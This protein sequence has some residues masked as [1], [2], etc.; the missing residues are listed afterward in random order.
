MK[1]IRAL[2]WT[3]CIMM[4][5]LCAGGCGG[6]EEDLPPAE[7]LSQ[8][9]ALSDYSAYVTLGAYTGFEIP[10]EDAEVSQEEMEERIA[11]TV[12]AY[13]YLYAAPEAVTDRAVAEGDMINI[14]FSTTVDGEN[15]EALFGQDVSYQIGSGQI[16][17]ALDAQ[18]VGKQPGGAY[19]LICTFPEDTAF[20]GLEGKTA[21]FHVTVNYIYGAIQEKPWGD[22][23]AAAM[24]GG[25]YT[26]ADAYRE[27]L[28]EQMR[29]TAQQE[30]E[31]AYRDG[32]WEAVL[33]GCVFRDL[34]E[35]VL[36][37]NAENYYQNAKEQFAYY[38]SYYGYTY[39]Q[40]ME[41]I[42]GMTDEQFHDQAYVYARTE[43]ERI[44]A[45]TEI[46]R[47]EAMEFTDEDYSR[48]AAELAETYG[49][50]SAGAFVEAYGEEYIREV[51]IT[52]QVE[53]FL[54]EQSKMVVTDQ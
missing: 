49:Y 10:V 2:F 42:Q 38:A 21:A 3:G 27:H 9:T 39:D 26:D 6:K 47:E 22:E 14:D 18:L 29:Q 43:L 35:E 32:L 50:D 33:E 40:Y 24:S 5:A 19:D 45:A 34:P 25:A 23:L 4:T 53:A 8:T 37:K 15:Q 51:L 28:Y 20:T 46:F 41:E 52:R 12:E 30:Q 48:G 11:Q 7:M 36:S 44:Y 54:M 31:K 16:H 13:N 17:P 1:N